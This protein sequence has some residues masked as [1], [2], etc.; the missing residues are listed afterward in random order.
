MNHNLTRRALLATVLALSLLGM[1]DAP[2]P[3][4]VLGASSLTDALNEIGPA[5]TAKTHQTVTLSYAASSA[6]A[7]QIEAG[8]PAD[9]FMSADTDWMDYLQTRNLIDTKT[10]RNVVGNRLVL[11]SPADSTVTIRITRHFPLAKLLGDGRLATGNPDSV[12]VGKYAK[13]ALTNLGVW[14]AVQDKIAAADNVRAALALVAR[15]EAPL[16]IVYRTD[17]LIEKKV[18]IVA[19]FPASSHG[20]ITYPAATTA[21]AHAGAADFVKFLSSPTAQAIFAKYGFDSA[22]K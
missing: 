16:G 9:V 20:P 21:R 4:V 14:E 11:I 12:P 2:P 18:R 10:R 7:R 6:L 5:Y 1:A 3:L 8:A 15:G 22:P 19:D 17:A 13:I